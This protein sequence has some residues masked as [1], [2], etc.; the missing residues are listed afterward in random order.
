MPTHPQFSLGVL[1][2]ALMC[3]G[4]ACAQTDDDDDEEE[5]APKAEMTQKEAES[6]AKMIFREDL[7]AGRLTTQK[8]GALFKC[9]NERYARKLT[10]E[11]AGELFGATQDLIEHQDR[12]ARLSD[13]KKAQYGRAYKDAGRL[14]REAEDSCRQELGIDPSVKRV[15][16]GFGTQ[17]K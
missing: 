8:A 7:G 16:Q 13:D 10:P 11:K 6:Y 9:A 12:G 3:A 1:L 2:L 14:Q 17:R 4:P 15:F 5:D